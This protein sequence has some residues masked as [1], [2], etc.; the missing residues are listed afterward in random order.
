MTDPR[1]HII[2]NINNYLNTLHDNDIEAAANVF[3]GLLN[4]TLRPIPVS[5]PT[6]FN[7][8]FDEDWHQ[9]HPGWQDRIAN[10]AHEWEQIDYWRAEGATVPDA[11][12]HMGMWHWAELE[13]LRTENAQL[14]A[15]AKLQHAS[16]ERQKATIEKQRDEIEWDH[17]PREA[18]NRMMREAAHRLEEPKNRRWQRES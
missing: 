3:T 9:Q 8:R 11:L 4:R 6:A 15:Q 17:L 13:K 16:I 18:Q 2:D 5:D 10:H 12:V 14:Q 7:A 1:Q